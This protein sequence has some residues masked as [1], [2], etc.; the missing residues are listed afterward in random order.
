MAA[1]LTLSRGSVATTAAS[2]PQASLRSRGSPAAA[3]RAR[4]PSVG[5]AALVAPPRITV[6]P[7][8]ASAGGV[9]HPGEERSRQDSFDPAMRIPTQGM[10]R[11]FGSSGGATLERS[12]L[13]MSQ[14]VVE[15]TPQ[16]DDGS[17]GGG[18]GKGI[19]NGG[20]GGDDGGDDD[21]YF[22]DFD[23]EEGDGDGEG[24]FRVALPELYDK[25][26]LNAVLSEWFRTVADLPL[27]LRQV[28]FNPSLNGSC[29][30]WA[31][32]VP[33]L[34]FPWF[35]TNSEMSAV[36]KLVCFLFSGRQGCTF[37]FHNTSSLSYP[38]LLTLL[39]V[40]C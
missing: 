24:F 17:G 30:Q 13:D 39:M 10:A 14:K 31:S 19:F 22:N 37:D 20:G 18:I 21:D 12:K 40:F 9:A 32:H 6:Q 2:P 33:C 29:L 7:L 36:H 34:A 5:P 11:G 23:G 4:K 26:T 1:R 8:V 15:R 35:C 16:L 38:K 27:I 25:V 28:R 3:L